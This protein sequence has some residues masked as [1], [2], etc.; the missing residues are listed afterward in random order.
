MS[1]QTD[2]LPI[3]FLSIDNLSQTQEGPID[4]P[5]QIEDKNLFISASY[6]KDNDKK[7]IEDI[8]TVQ[9]TRIKSFAYKRV[10]N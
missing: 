7:T 6:A 1:H 9:K 4:S 3:E 5:P 2:K 10:A 8:K